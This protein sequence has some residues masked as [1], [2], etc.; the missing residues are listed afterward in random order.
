MDSDN[1]AIPPCPSCGNMNVLH[2]GTIPDSPLFAGR[3]LLQPLPGGT[4]WTCPQCALKF[5]YPFLDTATL[6][7]LYNTA[8]K[9]AWQTPLE[10]KTDWTLALDYLN[11]NLSGHP[12]IVDIGCFD[13][14]FLSQLPDRW[15][16]FGVEINAVAAEK[17]RLAGISVISSTVEGLE[18]GPLRFD[19]IT[20]FDVVEHM[21]HPLAFVKACAKILKPGG[22]LII[23]TGNTSSLPWRL[24]GPRNLY[25]ICAEHVS[26]INCPWCMHA[27]QQ[28]G[29]KLLS[30]V[31]YRHGRHPLSRRLKNGTYNIAYALAPGIFRF[32]RSKSYGN[33]KTP[34]LWHYPPSW[35]SAKDH[36]LAIFERQT[37]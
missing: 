15:C 14:R 1:T 35:P 5:R 22:T 16:R 19:A 26:F 33:A 3:M 17:A 7:E 8:D 27:A 4:L 18:A 29:L 36:L 28:S 13:G 23:A 9:S 21:Q 25:A 12:A 31:E 32:F 30:T 2:S 34:N 10:N 20:A 11:S 37:P 6:S 24:L